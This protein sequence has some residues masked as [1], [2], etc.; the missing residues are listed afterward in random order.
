MNKEMRLAAFLLLLCCMSWAV[1]AYKCIHHEEVARESKR[2]T[3]ADTQIQNYPLYDFPRANN[4]Q[5]IRIKYDL[6]Y[7]EGDTKYT[8]YAA[9][10][11]VLQTSGSKIGDV[12]DCKQA[13]VLSTAARNYLVNTLLEDAKARLQR[14]FSVVP[15]Q[16][17]LM[18]SNIPKCGKDGV[19][20]PSSFVTDG[21]E[22]T[23]LYVFVT[24]RPTDGDVLAYALS[25]I[26]DQYSRSVV[27]LININPA[28][29]STDIGYIRTQ[30]G[31]VEHELTHVLGLSDSKY[32]K[33]RAPNNQVFTAEVGGFI[34]TPAVRSFVRSHFNCPTMVGAQLED[35]GGAGTSGS[36]W[37][38]MVFMNEY[39]TGSSVR[40]PVLTK[41]TNAYFLDSGWYYPNDTETDPLVWG[42]Q[43]GCAF[44]QDCSTWPTTDGYKCTPAANSAHKCTWD[45]QGKGKCD[46]DTYTG[47]TCPYIR[48]FVDAWCI[49]PTE[50]GVKSPIQ[51]TGEEFCENCR[52]F[53]STLFKRSPSGG[54]NQPICY[55][56][57]CV[58][59]S[60][61]KVH[62]DDWWYD[63]P[64]GG[65]VAIKD[66][67]GEISCP[68]PMP[69][70]LEAP[71]QT[72]RWPVFSF[73]T[74]DKGEPGTTI[75]ISGKYFGGV[76]E[77]YIAGVCKIHSII[78][79]SIIIATLPKYKDIQNPSNFLTSKANI[80]VKNHYGYNSFNYR[81]FNLKISLSK[82]LLKAIG[83]WL[84]D[85][86][87]VPLIAGV[88]IIALIF[89]CWCCRRDNVKNREKRFARQQ[90]ME[91]AQIEQRQR[92]QQQYEMQRA[93][94]QKDQ[95]YQFGYDSQ[96][97]RPRYAN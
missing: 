58:D 25:C 61:L 72:E 73:I 18:M 32:K 42:Y 11:E 86:W 23:D 78:N 10:N 55:K 4:T 33:F 45:L 84:A 46:S 40:N 22:D 53:M 3:L 76:T 95:Q 74:P 81:R 50:E 64:K 80:Y 8:C 63:C 35:G 93:K 70:C 92:Q 41:L 87:Y 15:I 12:Y 20:I 28:A 31:T 88:V 37:E 51:D 57:A 54:T 62:V 83:E 39:M 96:N 44:T 67:G 77:V 34:T 48:G 7:M 2:N 27:G 69:I 47:D 6:R 85:H 14:M 24:I 13:D 91:M 89:V 66:Y 56:T 75:T 59:A 1:E 43:Q 9:G 17:P 71:D 29:I 60:T 38:K 79:D 49:D 5:P 30:L 68:D 16:G 82:D 97:P 90:Q 26:D 19:L 65:G 94:S 21:V 36:H 52:C